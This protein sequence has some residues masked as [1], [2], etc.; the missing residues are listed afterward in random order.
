MK[1]LVLGYIVRGPLGGMA[2]HHLQYVIGLKN[3]GH[4]VLF[5]EDSDGYASCYNPSTN[6]VTTDPSYGLQFCKNIFTQH[7]L[8]HN[9]SYY[10]EHTNSWFGLSKKAV[11]N[12]CNNADV[13][14]NLSGINPIREWWLNVPTRCY[15]DTDPAFTQIKH[16][17][18][19][20]A[21]EIAKAHTHFATYGENFGKAICSIPNDGIDWKPTRQPVVLGKWNTSQSTQNRNWTTV[22]Q[23][24]SYQSQE[25]KG[26]VYG[27]KS[28]S[29]DEYI[30][31]PS[32]VQDIF[33][34]ALGSHAVTKC[35]LIDAGWKVK[36]PLG[37]TLTT[38]TYQQFICN[39]K[40][41]WSVAKQG[42]VVTKSGWFS[43]RSAVYMASGRPVIVQNTGFS[44]FLPVGKGLLTFTNMAESIACIEKVNGDYEY[45]CNEARKIVEEYF[46]SN[47]VL[48]DLLKSF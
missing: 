18:N 45:H 48:R 33:E 24:D 38:E 40:G 7:N 11:E 15:L 21:L 19:N 47:K 29:F 20:A 46:D 44:D 26:K 31:M 39:S 27:M 4:Q 14:L 1:I 6:E 43:E 8:Q 30:D 32:K 22:M 12:F 16:I 5:L 25:Y 10:D 36:D 42:Y 37:I 3:M 34:L 35:K 28:A 13:V 17:T 23:W 2:W 9:W 41:E